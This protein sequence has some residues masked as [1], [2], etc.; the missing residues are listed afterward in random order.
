MPSQVIGNVCLLKTRD[1]KWRSEPG[2]ARKPSRG[3]SASAPGIHSAAS[4]FAK[5]LGL[6]F[7]PSRRDGGGHSRAPL[8]DSTAGLDRT[9]LKRALSAA[10]SG[11][12]T[13]YYWPGIIYAVNW[14]NAE[15]RRSF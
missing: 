2:C 13:S 3:I 11:V 14:R 8:L 12:A 5:L 9:Q 4:A 7:P 6:A 1:P 15:K 10:H